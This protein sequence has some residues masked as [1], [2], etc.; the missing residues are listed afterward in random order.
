MSVAINRAFLLKT[1]GEPTETVSAGEAYFFLD[2]TSIKYKDDAQAIHT[3]AT[4]VSAEDVQDI[5]GT[6]ITSGNN[7]LT[8]VY[9]DV[10]NSFVITVVESN[11]VHQNLSGA[12][13]NTHAQIDSHI[14][15]TSN[16][17]AVT[18]AQVGLGSVDNTSDLSKPISTAT[19][20]ALNLKYDASNPNGYETPT[21]LNARDTAN[22]ARA[23]H[24]GTQLAST[25][26][27]LNETVQDMMSTFLQD[28]A[29]VDFTY[30]DAGNTG[31]FSVIPGAVNHNLLQNYLAAEHINHTSVNISAGTG[32][33]GGGDISA[34]RTL[35]IANTGVIASTY[36]G[37]AGVPQITVNSQG[38][39]TNIVN[40]AAL[41]LGDNF[42]YYVDDTLFTTTSGTNVSAA[43]FTTP[44]LYAG[45]YRV[46]MEYQYRVASNTVSPI[47]GMYFDGNLL[48]G[49]TLEEHSDTAANERLSRSFL[50][51][52]IVGAGAPHTIELRCRAETAGTTIQVYRVVCEIWRVN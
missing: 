48:G 14:A 42:S 2:G 37:S 46:H 23:N 51:Y 20:T 22:R 4:G 24:T 6:F 25:I 45:T 31:S 7:R 3:L 15:S 30:N 34:S 39:I 10:A 18:K 19:Q 40:G 27:D 9:N 32:L 12:G 38:Q 47:F 43:S 41:V 11:I 21:Q 29:S 50:E 52:T 33:T 1:R 8:A 13:T 26:S 36:G 17:H 28:S 5:I 16:P 35:S 49:E 44:N